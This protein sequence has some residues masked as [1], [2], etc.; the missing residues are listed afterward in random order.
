MINATSV[1]TTF[2]LGGQK[3][4]DDLVGKTF[5][6]DA[7]SHRQHV[8]VV[9][10][11]SEAGGVQAVA[12]GGAHPAHL[13]RSQLFALPAATE[14]D[15]HI[16]NPVTHGSTH[17][18]ADRRV[19]DRLRRVRS[20]VIHC[21][22]LVAKFCYEVLLEFEAGVIRTD[23]NA[24]CVRRIRRWSVHGARV[25]A[26]MNGR[27]LSLRRHART[28]SRVLRVTLDPRSPVIIGAGQHLHRAEGIDDSLDAIALMERAVLAATADAGLDGPPTPDAL[29]VV[30]LLSW[31]YGNPP[32]FLAEQLGIDPARLEYTAMGGNTPQSL[33]NRTALEIQAGALDIA[34]L[35]G[36]EAWRTRMRA[37]KTRT[38]LPWPK[39]AA[40]DRPTIIG[41]ELEMNLDAETLR[42]IN[43]PV[44]I[45]PMF[46]TALRAASGRTPEE[47]VR[48]LGRLW[49]GLSD[50]AAGNPYA[51]MQ[52]PKTADEITTVTSSNRMIGLPYPKLMNSNNDVDMAAAVIMCSVEAARRLGVPKEKWVFPHSGADCHEH[53]FVSNRDTFARTPAIE[54][55]GRCALE[56]AGVD[57]DDVS[58]IDLYSCFPSAVQLGA[59]SLGISLDRQWSR[60]GGLSFAGGPWN[61]YVMHAIA[62]VV[63]DLRERPGEFGLVWANG[64]YATKHAFGVYSTTP[65]KAFR[66]TEPQEKIDALPRRELATQLDAAG[67]ATIEAYTV[68]F[69]RDGEPEQAIASCLLPDG[70]RAWG[71]SSDPDLVDSMCAGE[72]VGIDAS[73]DD[74]GT[75]RVA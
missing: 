74:D 59:Q 50:V 25:Y 11:T 53:P 18:G 42:G 47:H 12:K 37:K 30:S 40:D 10:C 21:V 1:A 24:F 6:Y 41:K 23:R 68:M 3:R 44:Q 34:I 55:G 54:I 38:L 28:I 15:A 75:L 22:A 63:N 13:V 43:L 48:H 46:E 65:P 7:S 17:S 8:G 33:V 57:I 2:E 73:L 20:L 58:V 71:M 62:T 51:W 45:Y 70:R 72:W 66:H 36:G 16:G 56:L 27:P 26:S 60:T 67:S 39:A 14:H 4:L 52:E 69:S 61:N 5:A 32:R 31:R 9:V 35:T 64:G 49:S 19:V 29:R